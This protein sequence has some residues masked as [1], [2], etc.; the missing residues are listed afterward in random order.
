MSKFN[1]LR[2]ERAKAGGGEAE[3]RSRWPA[4]FSLYPCRLRG[5]GQRLP[6]GCSK[7]GTWGYKEWAQ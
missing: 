2:Q 4:G 6:E 1:L 3:G 7:G 5:W